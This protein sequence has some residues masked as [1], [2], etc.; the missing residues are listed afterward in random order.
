MIPKPIMWTL[1]D[2]RIIIEELQPL[3]RL[4]GFHLALGGGVLNLGR[5]YKDLDLY[6][7]PLDSDADKTDYVGLVQLLDN[8]WGAAELIQDLAYPGFKGSA[9]VAKLKYIP[10]GKRIDVFIIKGI[11]D[12]S[13]VLVSSTES[14]IQDS[15]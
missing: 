2:A 12:V 7:L 8:K 13:D 15:F 10:Q 3:S 5:S 1:E 14:I 6:F 9:Y 11:R 4:F